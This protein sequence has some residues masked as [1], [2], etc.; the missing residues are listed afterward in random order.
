MAKMYS[1]YTQ[2]QDTNNKFGVSIPKYSKPAIW[3]VLLTG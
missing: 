1:R 3:N 2:N